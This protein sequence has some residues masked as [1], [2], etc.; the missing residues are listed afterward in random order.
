[1]TEPEKTFAQVPRDWADMTEAEK[2]A[3]G[4]AFVRAVKARRST[5]PAVGADPVANEDQ[6]DVVDGAANDKP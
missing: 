6:P 2:D 5:A 4:V 1:M 3:W